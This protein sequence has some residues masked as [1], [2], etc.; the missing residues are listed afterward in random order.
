[1]KFNNFFFECPGLVVESE[2]KGKIFKRGNTCTT[3]EIVARFE[4]CFETANVEK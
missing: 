1:V 3:M 2:M 4:S